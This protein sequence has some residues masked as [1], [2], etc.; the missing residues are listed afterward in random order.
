MAQPDLGVCLTAFCGEFR[1]FSKSLEKSCKDL[2]RAVSEKS[3]AY[4]EGEFLLLCYNWWS[5]T[6]FA[7]PNRHHP[8]PLQ[9]H[10]VLLLTP[11]F[12]FL[13]MPSSLLFSLCTH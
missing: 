13:L 11:K 10:H 12:N 5:L 3:Q 1:S 6:F 7:I 4:V 2:R 8:N 9:C